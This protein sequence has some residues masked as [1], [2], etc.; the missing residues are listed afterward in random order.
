[1]K[2]APL[3]KDKSYIKDRYSFFSSPERSKNTDITMEYDYTAGGNYYH[4][5]YLPIFRNPS[6]YERLRLISED[7]NK[8]GS[9]WLPYLK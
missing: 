5:K 6:T 1:M 9:A 7:M 4:V 3:L 8:N 2:F